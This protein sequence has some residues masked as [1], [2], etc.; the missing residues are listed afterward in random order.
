MDET[1]WFGHYYNGKQACHSS[2]ETVA[3]RVAANVREY[4]KAF[5]NVIIGDG[6]PFPSITDQPHWQDDL[7][8]WRQALRANTGQPLAFIM[9]DISWSVAHWPDSLKAVQ[10][11]AHTNA[12]PVG[13]IYNAAPS[14]PS[15]TNQAWLDDARRNFTHMRT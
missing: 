4:Q 11:F 12:W 8:Q 14:P 1:L 6:E 3:E 5:P 13:I 10:T 7:K 2:I 9:V 15:M